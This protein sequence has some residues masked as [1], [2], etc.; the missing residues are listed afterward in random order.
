MHSSVPLLINITVALVV[1]FLGG[2]LAR[3]IGL[4]TIVGY[5]LAGIVIGPFTPGFVGDVET[6]QQLAELG[7]IFLM[8]GVGL[9][10][11][12]AQLLRVRDV[13]I[14]GALI[15]TLLATLA[16]VGLSQ[17]WGWSLVSGITLGLSIS[18]AS[19]VVLLRG[20]MDNRLLNTPH[21]Q[22]AVG[23]LVMEDIL[24][25]LILVLMP[26]LATNG[27]G[28]DFGHLGLTLLKA[29]AFVAIMF[30][31]GTRFIPWLLERAALTRSRELFVLVVLAVTL[32]TAMGASELF[33]V[34]LALGA[35]VAGAIISE[36]HLSHQVGADVFSFREAFS[37]LFFVSVGM[38]V[39]PVFLWEN[40]GQV[41]SL[42]ALVVV[43]KILIVLA[44]GMVFPRPAR[45]F[46]VVA[47]GLSQVGEFSFII[48]Q[49]GL[50]LGLLNQNQYSLILAAALFSITVNPFM[51]RLLPVLERFLPRIP[52]LWKKLESG[53]PLVPL[54]E[55]GLRN[56]VVIVGYG[57][58]GKHLFSVL[59]SLNIP[60]LVIE[61]DLERIEDLN[62]QKA[63]TLFGDA[64][65]SELL[66]HAYLKDA[67]VLVSTLP[68]E[69]AS[70]LVVLNARAMAPNLRIVARAETVAGLMELG[71]LG[72]NHVV[73]PELEGGLELVH[74][75]LLDLGYPLRE[76]HQFAEAFR[77]DNYNV[78]TLT[79]E[80]HRSLHEL[81]QAID[82]IDIIWMGIPESSPLAGQS[83][84]QANIRSRTGA[85]VAAMIR[86]GQVT[87]NPKSGTVFAAGDRIGVIGDDEQIQAARRLVEGV[88]DVE[89]SAG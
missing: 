47:L 35:F 42:T 14:P 10:F 39:N 21:G 23:W 67:K 44:M 25:V 18:V 54:P 11:S 76:V 31:G 75:T 63:Y 83:L 72:A 61:D 27:A 73:Q 45:T 60:L 6:I 32:G 84:A 28:F 77:R 34:S 5:L 22:V 64:A 7:V 81:L 4:P 65:N 41:A 19:T 8:L 43:G 68:D 52:G 87:P 50:A 80:E 79:D 48:G 82:G 74:H 88:P 58:V 71:R 33:G 40:L 1:A 70:A 37:V 38:L 89:L 66:T 51:Y 30:V 16:G 12:F 57:R 69:T 36:S 53:T 46:L 29:A 59:D 20:L 2:M 55:E 15:Q 56:H 9:H 24:S 49:G 17:L 3:R 78:E 85:S 13:A 26:A 62:R 86:E